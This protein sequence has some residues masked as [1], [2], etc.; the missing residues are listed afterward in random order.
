MDVT[1]S[2]PKQNPEEAQNTAPAV[3]LTSSVGA[4]RAARGDRPV[5]SI[6]PEQQRRALKSNCEGR[7]SAHTRAI[8]SAL[9]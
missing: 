4:D 9:Y 5:H 7:I 2:S 1:A 6:F 3:R 8:P